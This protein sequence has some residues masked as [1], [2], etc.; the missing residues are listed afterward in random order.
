MCLHELA[1]RNHLSEA[2]AVISIR[3][4]GGR[5]YH[6]EARTASAVASKA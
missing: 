6:P 5:T 2:Y 3:L 1:T 4:Y